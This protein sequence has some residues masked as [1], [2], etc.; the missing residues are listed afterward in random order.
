MYVKR[1]KVRIERI[2]LDLNDVIV[3]SRKVQNKLKI[4]GNFKR[5][6]NLP[7]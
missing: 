3:D 6:I 1:D 2:V 7:T 4:E 5:I